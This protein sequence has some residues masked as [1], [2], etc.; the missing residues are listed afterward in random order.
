VIKGLT[1]F[2]KL[3]VSTK[4]T[5]CV[6]DEVTLAD[7]FLIPQLY[8]AVRFEVDITQW[9]HIHEVHENLKKLE[10]FDIAHANNQIDAV[11]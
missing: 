4:G 3:L 9:P 10:V 6:G 1:A 7:F 8:T 5:Y 2:E 11:K